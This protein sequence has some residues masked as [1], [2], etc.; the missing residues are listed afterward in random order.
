MAI[1]NLKGSQKAAA[2]L[3]I[4]GVDV[5]SEVFKYFS[6]DE[7]E[8]LTLE[9]A[10]LPLVTPEDKDALLNEF[11]EMIMA[12]QF[13]IKGGSDYAREVLSRSVGSERAEDIF[14]KLFGID[15]V[16]GVGSGERKP[17]D[18][19]KRVDANQLLGVL[20]REHPQTIAIVLAYAPPMQAS[21]V[22]TQ[23]P[24][25]IQSDVV[26]RLAILDK[27]SP[28][29]VGRVEAFLKTQLSSMESS[30]G[31]G[32]TGKAGG[33][34]SVVSMLQEV[35][36]EIERAVLDGVAEQDPELAEE[37][38]KQMFTFEDITKLDDRS[39]QRVLREVDIRDLALCLKGASELAS[40]MVYKNM[41][42]RAAAM[43][44][45]EIE[46]LGAVRAKDIEEAQQKVVNV[47]RQLEDAGEIVVARGSGGKI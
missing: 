47:I 39:A 21:Q 14:G 8:K 38:R 18:F 40:E 31:A 43:L 35:D 16:G 28:D 23:L 29:A 11:Q 20:Q 33:V 32:V 30:S 2:L 9:V 24:T 10:N 7:I 3:V 37:I 42:K 19:M 17:F 45:E 44:K 41:P 27:S 36:R 13:V 26:R 12:Q 25:E 1:E 34:P 22:L 15:G 4:L 5:A 46:F 6:D